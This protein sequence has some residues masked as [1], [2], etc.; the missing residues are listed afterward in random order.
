MNNNEMLSIVLRIIDGG[1]SGNK[2][3][4]AVYARFLA[5]KLM[6]EGEFE[7]SKRVI[8]TALGKDL[9]IKPL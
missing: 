8:R 6:A 9:K 2:K 5:E 3:K 4:V 1:V 7:A